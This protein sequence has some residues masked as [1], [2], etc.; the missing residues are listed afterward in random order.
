M[1]LQIL[2]DNNNSWII[3][4]II[5]Y[6]DIK[7]N[8]GLECMFCQTHEEVSEGDVLVLLS[9]EKLFK[10]LHLNKYNLVVHESLLPEGKGWSP[11]TWQILEGKSEIPVTLFEAEERVDSG[12][13][14]GVEY[15]RLEGHELINEIRALQSESTFKLLD[16]FIADYPHISGV[17]QLGNSTFYPRRT[18]KDSEFSIHLPL[19]EQFNLLR[20]C[21]NERYPAFFIVKGIKYYLKIEKA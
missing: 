6:V 2:C 16:K 5:S 20:V 7:R 19:S 3:P 9:C 4:Y 15:I 14:Y 10:G 11:L 13:I 1:K 8:Q 12:L 17:K 21:D 18:A